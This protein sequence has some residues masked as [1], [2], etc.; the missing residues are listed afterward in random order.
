M[1]AAATA[2]QEAGRKENKSRQDQARFA[3]PYG[4]ASAL[5]SSPGVRKSPQQIPDIGDARLPLLGGFHAL[6]PV[7]S[8]LEN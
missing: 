5:A 3:S 2:K 8:Q 1:V 6:S 4:A 7:S